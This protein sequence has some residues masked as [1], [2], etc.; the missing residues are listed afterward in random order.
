MCTHGVGQ[1]RHARKKRERLPCAGK[2]KSA[3]TSALYLSL[4]SRYTRRC[5]LPER[6][7]RVQTRTVRG[8]PSIITR[9]RWRLGTQVRRVLRLEWL[10]W[11]PALVPFLQIAHTLDMLD[12]SLTSQTLVSY[13]HAP[14]F[15][16]KTATFFREKK[17]EAGEAVAN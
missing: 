3:E 12:T 14:V 13:H 16:S 6:R 9:A 17:R 4:A 15:A 1:A 7:Q 8:L 2:T 10:T 5:T 11:L